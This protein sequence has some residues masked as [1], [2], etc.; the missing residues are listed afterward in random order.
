MTLLT[1][2]D[3]RP[4]NIRTYSTTVYSTMIRLLTT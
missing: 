1:M 4:L 2:A 3:F